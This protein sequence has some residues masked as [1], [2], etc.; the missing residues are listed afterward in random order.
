[1]NNQSDT[2]STMMALYYTM[3][4][5][6]KYL[7]ESSLQMQYRKGVVQNLLKLKTLTSELSILYARIIV[8]LKLLC[9]FV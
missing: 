3:V 7:F 4:K 2:K 6:I 8:N 9:N 5:I 1:M